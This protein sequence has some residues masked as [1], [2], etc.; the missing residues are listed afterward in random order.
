MLALTL[1]T[2]A[3]LD[4][5]AKAQTGSPPAGHAGAGGTL[6][7]VDSKNPKRTASSGKSLLMVKYK[8]SS[9]VVAA[10][11]AVVTASPDAQLDAGYPKWSGEELVDAR[12][13]SLDVKYSG[14]VSSDVSALFS[15][16]GSATMPIVLV[17]QGKV[18]TN[19]NLDKFKEPIKKIN[20]ALET[21]AKRHDGVNPI[22]VSGSISY[23]TAKTDMY[24]NG[25][26]TGVATGLVGNASVNMA[27]L[28]GKTPDFPTPWPGLSIG[29]GAATSGLALK[30]K[31]ELKYDDQ[32]E[33]P[34]VASKVRLTAG[35]DVSV[36]ATATVGPNFG[37][38]A[39]GVTIS[40]AAIFALKFVGELKGIGRSIVLD[41]TGELGSLTL[42]YSVGAKLDVWG[43]DADW[44][45]YEN[46]S[47]ISK[48]ETIKM[49]K[50]YVIASW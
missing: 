48:G 2:Y 6:S 14:T 10:R 11:Q 12:D 41:G 22:S 23:A 32:V 7:A 44:K 24:A 17:D 16:S 42:N 35:S 31:G 18:T 38:K 8:N 46:S 50:P 43:V 27:A 47:I 29:V 33:N 40:G 3:S 13:G 5:Q 45:I 19:L 34:W 49:E 21:I 15:P 37:G 36:T 20:D 30:V 26:L 28:E 1:V 25:Q 4:G 9:E 39:S